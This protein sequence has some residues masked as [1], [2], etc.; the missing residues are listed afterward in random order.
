[1]P[2][3]TIEKFRIP[4]SR[5][6]VVALI[7]FILLSAN[8]WEDTYVASLLFASG[9]FLVAIASLGRLWCSLYIGGYKKNVL[10]TDGPYSICRHPLY[11]FSFLGAVGV[12]LSTETFLITFV[13]T[14]S[15]AMYYKY[16]I[17]SEEAV[18][19][20]K[21]GNAYKNYRDVTPAL[22]PKLSLLR[23]P[24]T[25]TVNP[26]VFRKHAF[27]ALWFVWIVGII[28]IIEAFH[29]LG[30]LPVVFKIY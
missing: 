5:L 11:F 21:H 22:L 3:S 2:V 7:I 17:H 18:L 30:S 20:K 16:V 25:Y 13:I 29:E 24:E 9:C 19:L 12:G 1:M 10:I 15:Y 28:E 8:R 23:E 4:I 27:D 14:F 6:L 26:R